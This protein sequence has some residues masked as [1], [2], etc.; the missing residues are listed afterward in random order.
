MTLALPSSQAPRRRLPMLGK[1]DSEGSGRELSRHPKDGWRPAEPYRMSERVRRRFRALIAVMLPPPPAPQI[2]DIVDRVE[3]Y[4][5]RFMAHMH[6]I[7]A[8]GMWLAI[9][10]L[11]WAPRLLLRS[12]RRLHELDRERASQ[13]LASM[14]SGSS[15]LLRTP[16]ISVRALVLSAYFDQDEVH[17]AMRY[18]PVPFIKDRLKLR[19]RLLRPAEALAR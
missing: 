4:V 15:S 1:R 5:R 10:L 7:A 19:Q 9:V 17:R 13:L 11:D 8:R 2:P 6:P 16:V 3:L 18:A 12:F 14:V